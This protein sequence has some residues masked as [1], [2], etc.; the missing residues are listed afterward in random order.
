MAIDGKVQGYDLYGETPAKGVNPVDDKGIQPCMT[1][2][3]QPV[4]KNSQAPTQTG[5]G[6]P[7][8]KYGSGMNG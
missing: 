6:L 4:E 5:G 8:A 7:K 3:S 1:P 2:M